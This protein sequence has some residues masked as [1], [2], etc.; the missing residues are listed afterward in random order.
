MA[1][2]ALDPSSTIP[3]I[4][5]SGGLL[6]FWEHIYYCTKSCDQMFFLILIFFNSLTCRRGW[7]LAYGLAGNLLPYRKPERNRQRCGLSGAYWRVFGG[8]AL[9]PFLNIT[10]SHFRP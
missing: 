2:A 10:I 1:Q 8:M 9:I 6:A 5:A 3:M 4:G 7:C